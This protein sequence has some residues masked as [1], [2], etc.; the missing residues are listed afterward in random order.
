[1]K[2]RS[3]LTVAL[4]AVIVVAALAG[5]AAAKK[6]GVS[7]AGRGTWSHATAGVTFSGATTGAPFDGATVGSVEADDGT[8][9][10]WPGCEPASGTMTTTSEDSTLTLRLWGNLCRAVSPAGYL[11]FRGWY[12]VVDYSGAKGRRVADGVGGLGMEFLAD[13]YAQWMP[14]GDLY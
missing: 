4:A 12:Q 13:G 1:M 8:L 7:Q 14:Q 9:P 10:P 5:P 2:T 11:V 6:Y 3:I